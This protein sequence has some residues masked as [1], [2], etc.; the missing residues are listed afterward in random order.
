MTT[1][2]MIPAIGEDGTLFP[3]EKLRAHREGRFHLAV[4]VFIFDGDA[5]LIQRRA[6]AK[7]HC[8]GQWANTCCTH[9]HW[10][11]DAA[12]CANRRLRE[13]LGVELALSPQGVIEYAAD[14]GGGLSEHERVTL[15]FGHAAQAALRLR[16]DPAEVAETRW[17][18]LAELRRETAA[19]PAAFTPWLR[20]YLERLDRLAA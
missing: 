16:P 1:D 19:R 12:A 13:E 11:E 2:A 20:I 3:M 8:A 4:S 5:L 18:D 9:P 7:Y 10:G 17:I 6:D 15:F 14:C